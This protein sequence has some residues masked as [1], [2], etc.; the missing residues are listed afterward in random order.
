[1]RTGADKYGVGQVK[2]SVCVLRPSL[3]K[4]LWLLGDPCRGTTMALGGCS[5]E[6]SRGSWR[7]SM[8]L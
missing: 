7:P 3:P 6:R 5:V 4:I 8:G 1:M 2:S